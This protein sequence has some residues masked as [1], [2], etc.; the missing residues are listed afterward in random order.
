MTFVSKNDLILQT[1]AP[2]CSSM[3]RSHPDEILFGTNATQ[4]GRLSTQYSGLFFTTTE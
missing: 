4:R 1:A 2:R 3:R